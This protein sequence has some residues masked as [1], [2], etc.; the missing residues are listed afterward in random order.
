MPAVP[1]FVR[2]K[3]LPSGYL[4]RPCDGGG[5]II[6]IVDHFDLEVWERKL[7]FKCDKSMLYFVELTYNF[8][9]FSYHVVGT[10]S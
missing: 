2:A 8:G 3:M 7:V 6:Y 10:C 9:V 4:I 5:S 1:H